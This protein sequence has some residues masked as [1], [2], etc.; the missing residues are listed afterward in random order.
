MA[1]GSGVAAMAASL[2]SALA[3]GAS[4][5]AAGAAAAG[6]SALAS[7]A[8]SSGFAA[9]ACI[10]SAGL[11][12]A[13]FSGSAGLASG[14]CPA[15]AGTSGAASGTAAADILRRLLRDR[16]IDAQQRQRRRRVV[17]QAGK[18]RLGRRPS[19]GKVGKFLM[20]GTQQA[21]A[22]SPKFRI[23]IDRTI[24][25]NRKRKPGSMDLSSTLLDRWRVIDCQGNAVTTVWPVREAR[26]RANQADLRVSQRPAAFCCKICGLSRSPSTMAISGAL[27]HLCR[28]LAAITNDWYGPNFADLS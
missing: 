11:T 12:A 28:S 9:S 17:I 23:D 4:V 24:A 27:R 20:R 21:A 22:P 25:V 2:T 13:S 7:F 10:G 1:A 5:S 15:G 19:R 6:V 14:A 26:V 18:H 3:T 8:G 16:R